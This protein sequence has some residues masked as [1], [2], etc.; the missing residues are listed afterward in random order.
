MRLV[1][2]GKG[3]GDMRTFYVRNSD[4][5]QRLRIY[6]FLF[7]EYDGEAG[8]GWSRYRCAPEH[9]KAFEEYTR[10]QEVRWG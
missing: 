8:D 3:L 9:E 7:A 2:M 1:A 6:L 4:D 10:R 5:N